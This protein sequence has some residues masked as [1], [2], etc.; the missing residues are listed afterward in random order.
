MTSLPPHARNTTASYLPGLVKMLAL[1][2]LG[3]SGACS[4]PAS[5]QQATGTEGEPVDQNIP[6]A[7]SIA[8][9]TANA[10]ELVPASPTSVSNCFPFGTNT[11]DVRGFMGFI[12]RN[13][14]AFELVPGQTIAFDLGARNDVDT[15]RN[16][17]FA[18]ANKNPGPPQVS[19]VSIISQDITVNADGWTQVVYESQVPLNPRG[20]LVKGDYELVYTAEAPFSFPGGGLI[21]GFGV[22]PPG[23]YVD[24]GC[25]QVVVV[26]T[27]QD[28]SGNF[29][30]RF[31]HAPDLTTGVLDGVGCGGATAVA[32]G[33]MIIGPSPVDVFACDGFAPPFVVALSLNSGVNRAIPSKAQLL[34]GDGFPVTDLDIAAAPVV[35]V[36]FTPVTTGVAE[37]LTDQREPLG[38][39]DTGNIFRFDPDTQSWVYNL[40]TKQYGA[41]G[42]YVVTMKSG[43][44][45]SYIIDPTCSG[46]F[47]RLK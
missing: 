13:V 36:T 34:D 37:D 23:T 18:A 3:L 20:N 39:A 5:A 25:E 28:A 47:E 21:V 43:D 10:I 41:S 45:S 6:E 46:Q 44:A 32:L 35:N 26:T 40:G 11:A 19:G 14:P 38:H 8:S 1:V 29:Y 16:I 7:L 9:T 15:R 2:L 17:F 27:A 30:A 12:Y 33:G 42:T 22:T 31:C 24:P 4:Q